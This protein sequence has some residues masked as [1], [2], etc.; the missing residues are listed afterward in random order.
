M[1]ALGAFL[2]PGTVYRGTANSPSALQNFFSRQR[3]FDH[4]TTSAA[5]LW[6]DHTGHVI[7]AIWGAAESK[8]SP[9]IVT[10]DDIQ[11]ALNMNNP[12][13]VGNTRQPQGECR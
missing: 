10:H 9:V 4:D 1:G 11:I 2:N 8:I 6:A 13:R 12:M 3:L 5:D 7:R